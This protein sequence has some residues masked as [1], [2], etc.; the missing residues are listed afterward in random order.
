MTRIRHFMAQ[1]HLH[2]DAIFERA[3]RLAAERDWDG[4]ATEF[5][6]FR[7]LVLQHFDAEETLLF[8]AFE[9]K[10]GMRMGPTQV[11]RG[12]HVQMRQLMDAASAAL[13]QGEGDGEEY[14]GH[15]E[16]LLIMMQQHNLKEENVLY[17]L[18]DQHLSDQ[19]STLLPRLQE[20]L[21]DKA[22]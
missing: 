21:T 14:S 22:N 12:E 18:C 15:A 16:T 5:A 6:Q 9:E 7:S 10:S 1:D 17:P 8:P 2:C 11:M 13:L 19:A 3:G 20:M 4:A